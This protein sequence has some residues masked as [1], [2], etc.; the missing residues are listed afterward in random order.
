[1]LPQPIKTFVKLLNEQR[2]HSYEK[3]FRPLL[4]HHKNVLTADLFGRERMVSVMLMCHHGPLIFRPYRSV[5]VYYRGVSL[6]CPVL[7][8]YR[9]RKLTGGSILQFENLQVGFTGQ[10]LFNKLL[11][12][13][14]TGNLLQLVAKIIIQH[15]RF[16]F[17][18]VKKDIRSSCAAGLIQAV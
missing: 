15:L 5:N 16:F 9:W 17:L 6:A 2:N 3:L 4:D 8:L 1:M 13:Y 11:R 12:M 10:N 7:L 18:F 14:L